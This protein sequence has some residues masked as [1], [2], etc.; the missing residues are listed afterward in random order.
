MLL[1]L[2]VKICRFYHQN[3][4]FVV[5]MLMFLSMGKNILRIYFVCVFQFEMMKP[6]RTRTQNIELTLYGLIQVYTIILNKIIPMQ[7]NLCQL[8]W[9]RTPQNDK[10]AFLLGT[11]TSIQEAT[12]KHCQNRI[13]LYIQLYIFLEHWTHA[14]TCTRTNWYPVT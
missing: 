3:S 5:L 8:T 9:L 14:T 2:L 12:D 4:V 10:M 13:L 7:R 6:T 1:Y 11:I